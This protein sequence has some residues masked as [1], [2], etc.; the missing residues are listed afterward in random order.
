[1]HKTRFAIPGGAIS[2]NFQYSISSNISRFDKLNDPG[3]EPGS[4]KW[5]SGLWTS[6]KTLEL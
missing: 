1:M 5:A 2:T 4:L 3:I 6:E